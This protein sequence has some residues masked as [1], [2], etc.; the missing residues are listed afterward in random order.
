MPY[1]L[2]YQSDFGVS[3]PTAYAAI[4]AVTWAGAPDIS[5]A[6][7]VYAT[8]DAHTAKSAPL[9]TFNILVPVATAGDLLTSLYAEITSQIAAGDVP[10]LAGA[11]V[12]P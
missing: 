3:F 5:I 1:Q 8:A 6:M 12:V 9:T 7:A 2:P 11:A 4:V 10:A